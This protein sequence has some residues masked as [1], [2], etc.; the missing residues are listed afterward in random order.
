MKNLIYIIIFNLIISQ[1][2]F[3]DMPDSTGVY[4]PVI[5]EQCFGLDVGDE[6]GL[7]DMS[8]LNSNDCTDQYS[9]ILVGAGIYNG[10]Q[11]TISGFGSLDYCDF[12]DGYQLP[13]W[14]GGHNIIVKV[15]D[16][17][18]NIEYIPEVNLSVGSG[19]WGDIYTVIET[20]VVSELSIKPSDQFSLY[21]V[22]PN[23]FNSTITFN[24][25]H[26]INSPLNVSI[27]DSSGKLIENIIHSNPLYNE[28]IKW[29]ASSYNSGIYFVN[30][31]S[32]DLFLTKKISLIK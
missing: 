20:L 2:H 8:G 9:E 10:G 1:I 26:N 27:Y 11:L 24:I 25:N 4:Q 21:K 14:I 7:F 29:N 13:G 12:T 31:K 3:S 16:S 28:T 30:F 32:S 15:W 22:Y 23:P 5:I 18:E 19:Q 17:S 6:I